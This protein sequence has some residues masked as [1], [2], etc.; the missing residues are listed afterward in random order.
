VRIGRRELQAHVSDHVTR[1]IGVPLRTGWMR[2]SRHAANPGAR[3][4]ARSSR[5]PDDAS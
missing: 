4:I 3:I 2:G 1:R 5:P